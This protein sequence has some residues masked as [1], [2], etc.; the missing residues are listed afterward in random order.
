M[1]P[2]FTVVISHLREQRN[3]DALN[4]CLDCLWRNTVNDFDLIVANG[5][6]VGYYETTNR[7]VEQATT[8][9]VVIHNSDMFVAPRWDVAMLELAAPDTICTAVLIETG[10]LGVRSDQITRNFGLTP[11]TFRRAEFE[12]FCEMA[13]VPD[14]WGMY[15][16]VMMNRKRWL[17]F[18]GYNVEK[19]GD[20]F[21]SGADFY[22]FEDWLAA[23]NKIKRGRTFAYH[24]GRWSQAEWRRP[25]IRDV[26]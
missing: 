20:E 26:K 19:Y 7:L 18:E 3:H 12:M 2:A 22:T 8:E 14:G 13:E 24:L 25:E 5:N 15:A 16:P 21:H 4:I 17:D 1:T 9:Y 6:P 23:G 11:E 10:L